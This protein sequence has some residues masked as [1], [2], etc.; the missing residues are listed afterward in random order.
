MFFKNRGKQRDLTGYICNSSVLITE[1]SVLQGELLNS[2]SYDSDRIVHPMTR[3]RLILIL[4]LETLLIINIKTISVNATKGS[5]IEKAPIPTPRCLLGVAVVNERIYA[6]GGSNQD[7]FLSI[8]EVYNPKS[9]IWIINTP[10]P[11]SR[12]AFGIAVYENRIY[13]FGGYTKG[14][15]ATNI[16]EVYDPKTDTWQRLA[17]MPTARMNIQAD[18]VGDKI[19]LMG[20]NPAGSVNEVYD[21]K[22]KTWETKAS[23]P[24]PVSRYVSTVI[25]NDIYI[26]T[27]GLVQIYNVGNDT[28]GFGTPPLCLI[29]HA[30]ANAIIDE[31]GY[32]RIYVFG[33]DANLPDW[34]LGVGDDPP[35]FLIP[36]QDFIIQCYYPKTD[37]WILCDSMPSA[38]FGTSTIVFD[39]GFFV[40]GGYTVEYPDEEFTL[41][42]L[43]TYSKTVN[44]YIPLEFE[45]QT[46]ITDPSYTPE[47][48]PFPTTFAIALV[49]VLVVIVTVLLVYFKKYRK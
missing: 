47:P 5:W 44:Q 10:M 4:I 31:L 19:F 17:P 8:N 11:T 27:S 42:P 34:H 35:Y 26:M 39:D 18:V 6:I 32:E 37:N 3:R 38:R 21:P 40:V 13:C 45:T 48:E 43:I 24:T 1:Q 30:S 33:V 12:S 36:D 9:N 28:W 14:F 23:I 20:G 2:Y 29:F 16:T 49:V 46:T 15:I 41:N 7:G 22:T 25:E